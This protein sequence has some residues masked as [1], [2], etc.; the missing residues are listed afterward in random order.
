[1]FIA[2]QPARIVA[3]T[4]SRGPVTLRHVSVNSLVFMEKLAKKGLAEHDFM[5]QALHHHLVK[6]KVTFGS[7]R[8]WSQADHEAIAATWSADPNTFAEELTPDDVPGSFLRAYRTATERWMAGFRDLGKKVAD[9]WRQQM[10]AMAQQLAKA[11]APLADVQAHIAELFRPLAESLRE[12]LRELPREMREAYATLA[13]HGWYMDPEL[14]MPAL[15]RL[16]DDIREGRSHHAERAL[17]T[18]FRSRLE[19]VEQ[20]LSRAFPARKKIIAAA[21][22]AHRR[23]EYELSIPVLLAQADGIAVECFGRQLFKRKGK[24]LEEHLKTVAVD[25]LQGI[26]LHPLASPAPISASQRERAKDFR[27]LNR[28]QVLHGES[29]DYPTEENGLK[30]I[31]LISWVAWVGQRSRERNAA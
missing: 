4:P 10:E 19:A 8:R 22:R 13:Q 18:H 21:L 16:A 25:S 1:M 5:V 14:P 31:S 6:P 9:S 11:A 28:H 27:G 3:K 26:L 15:W 2:Q 7:F 30:A 20:R 29:T 12:S 24:T 23:R 17:V